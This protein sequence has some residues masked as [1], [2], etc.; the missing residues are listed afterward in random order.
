MLQI[1]SLCFQP[2]EIWWQCLLFPVLAP[3]TAQ[4]S[5]LSA[6]W[7]VCTVISRMYNRKVEM[8]KANY[9]P[10]IVP[11]YAIG[12]TRWPLY[13]CD[14]CGLFQLKLIDNSTIRKSKQR[15]NIFQD[16]KDTIS[17][18]HCFLLLIMFRQ[19]L[20]GSL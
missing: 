3:S 5:F 19:L 9:C 17:N 20:R 10:F 18:N 12:G 7:K 13:K 8:D 6:P 2:S 15:L 4:S 14:K 11:K 16:H 1:F